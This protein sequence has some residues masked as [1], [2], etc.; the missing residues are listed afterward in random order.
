MKQSL[1]KLRRL[2]AQQEQQLADKYSAP[3]KAR[4]YLRAHTKLADSFLT[5]LWH[6]YPLPAAALLIAVGGYGRQELYP[7]SDID[8]LILLPDA[9]LT[10]RH[11]EAIV[12]YIGALWD[13]GLEV[14]HSV[15]TLDECVYEA[16]QDITVQTSLIDSRLIIGN[17]SR[18]QFYY[19]TVC[20]HIE[21][22]E[23]FEAKMLEQQQRHSR[24]QNVTYNLEPNIKESPGGLR[25]LHLIGWIAAV[26]HLGKNWQGLIRHKILTLEEVHKLK[27]AERTLQSYRIHLHLL[28][29]RHEDKILFDYQHAMANVFHFKNNQS[30]R[31][32]ELL[33][34]CYY[35]AARI[36]SQLTPLIIQT[37][38]SYLYAQ[39]P[40]PSIR[41]NARF[42]IRQ[43]MLGLVELDTFEKVPSTILELFLL[44]QRQDDINS[45]DPQTLRALWNTRG[46]IDEAFRDNPDHQA[47]F[48]SILREPRGLTRVLRIMNK[49][50]VL[51]RYIPAFGA[52]VGRMQHD[53]FHVYTVDEHTLILLRNLR[54]FSVPAY[55]HEYPL[56]SR[57]LEGFARPEVLYLAALFHDI[58]KGRGGDHS[59][60]GAE[61]ARLFC[62]KHALIKE[63]TELVSWL[64]RY[65]LKMSF[66]AQKQDMYDPTI[67]REFTDFVQDER[68][69]TALYLLTVADIRATN[70][71]IW[72]AWKAKLLEDLYHATLAQLTVQHH[73]TASF[74]QIRQDE[75]L[76]LIRLHGLANDAHVA[77]WKTLDPVY[78]LRHNA[79][80]IAWH[81]R[82][83]HHSFLLHTP[84]IRAQASPI[85]EGLQIL[86]YMPDQADLFARICRFFEYS[87]YSIVDAK[88][89][90]THNHYAL[91]SFY[92]FMPHYTVTHYRDQM[93]LIEYELNKALLDPAPISTPPS[94][95]LSRQLKHFPFYPHVLLR[96]DESGQYYTLSITAGDRTGLLSHIAQILM[97]HKIT[98][99]T[100][101][102]MTFGERAEDIF[103][104]SGESLADSKK[105]IQ[106][107]QDLLQALRV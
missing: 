105:Q 102:I 97:K 60:L 20:G 73:T 88:I 79:N 98:I 4:R 90:T 1:A 8:L 27:R 54:R 96:A 68:H 66:V 52:I 83:L 74:M 61:D 65:H 45:V 87:Q 23:F 6:E 53:L 81:T 25:E 46:L 34:A 9:E 33:M 78:F 16:N 31:A 77:F 28:A 29:K 48:M 93:N 22:K 19:H 63:D 72:N 82:L 64:V 56:C 30:Y 101:K 103:L 51:G 71:N 14:G 41:I 3:A 86:I 57:L 99:H 49:Y 38:K 15:R 104:V 21:A 55:T 47:L 76:R 84:I 17:R 95:R 2:Y 58:A 85:G 24:F 44:M 107:E 50:G 89:H 18:F 37:L 91:D 11:K 75:A 59:E 12:Q 10:Q 80:E 7:A 5:Q 35:R 100:A 92:V 39:T 94:G 26:C 43:G 67:V 69:L 13:I 106:L 42:A 62:E 40:M 70:P 36:I 32:S